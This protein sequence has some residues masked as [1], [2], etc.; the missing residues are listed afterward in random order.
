LKRLCRAIVAAGALAV[1]ALGAPPEARAAA[2]FHKLNL[3]LSG[4]PTSIKGG[5]FLDTL[6]A[7]NTLH[8]GK[9]GVEGLDE[10]SFGW[11]FDAQVQYFVRSNVALSFGAGQLRSQQKAEV[12]PRLQQSITYRAEVITVP[13]HAGV[14]YYLAPYNQGDFQARMFFGGG[15]LSLVHSRGTIQQTEIGTDSSTTFGNERT[16]PETFKNVMSGNA[17]GYYLQ[18]GAHMWFPSRLNVMLAV[19]YR[20]A[21]VR[22]LIND[23]TRQPVIFRGEPVDLDVGGVGARMAIGIG[24]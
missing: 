12:L 16:P 9:R 15:V 8:P 20:S 1:V 19:M 21:I 10:P 4:I 18:A 22:D 13:I 14:D 23:A 2:E 17:P 5:G 3:V 11:H 7:Y 6:A 24:L